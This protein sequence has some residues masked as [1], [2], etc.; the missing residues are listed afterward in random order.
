[1]N[2]I[3]CDLLEYT[4]RTS[5]LAEENVDGTMFGKSLMAKGSKISAP[6]MIMK[7]E[8]GTCT[9]SA[10]LGR[11]N[12]EDGGKKRNFSRDLKLGH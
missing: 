7:N 6:G 8:K 9:S 3:T 10:G 11:E 1:M 5:S 2:E 12:R 4:E